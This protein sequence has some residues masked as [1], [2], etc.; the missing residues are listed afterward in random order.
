M[1]TIIPEREL[2]AQLTAEQAVEAAY[3]HELA[4]VASK[5]Q[6]NLPVLIK[7]PALRGIPKREGESFSP[8]S[9]GMSMQID[10]HREIAKP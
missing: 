8:L 5:L 3:A 1:S 7:N 6:R 10:Y 4:E 9:F 2:P